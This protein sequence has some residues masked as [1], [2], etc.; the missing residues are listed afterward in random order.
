M[1]QDLARS[2]FGLKSRSRRISMLSTLLE[3][4]FST[5]FEL[6]APFR[7][8]GSATTPMTIESPILG[9]ACW[10]GAG[11]AA[12]VAKAAA[13][14]NVAIFDPSFRL[15]ISVPPSALV[16]GFLGRADAAQSAGPSN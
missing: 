14:Q 10:A 11:A 7:M 1:V 3:T 12:N 9:L 5:K 16:H 2:G 13:A 4:V 15:F 6:M 8:P